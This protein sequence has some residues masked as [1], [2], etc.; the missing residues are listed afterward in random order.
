MFMG[1]VEFLIFVAV[2]AKYPSPKHSFQIPF[3]NNRPTGTL[4]HN[5]G[6]LP[7]IY[8]TIPDFCRTFTAQSRIFAAHLPHNPLKRSVRYRTIG[9]L[10][11]H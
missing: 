11:S 3:Q 5:F 1:E 7:H 10:K 6:F 8:R 9:L 2:I 4:P